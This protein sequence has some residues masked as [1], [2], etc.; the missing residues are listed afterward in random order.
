MLSI[1]A[2][3]ALG[4]HNARG[5]ASAGAGWISAGKA[6]EREIE[7]YCGGVAIRTIT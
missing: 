5:N 6:A 7:E 2:S 1:S 3:G 4:A